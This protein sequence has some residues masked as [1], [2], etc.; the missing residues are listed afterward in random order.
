MPER[1]M[2]VGNAFTDMP[3]AFKLFAVAIL[4][5][6]C[7][8]AVH[9]GLVTH[10]LKPIEHKWIIVLIVGIEFGLLHWEP[11]KF[12]STGIAGSCLVYVYLKTK[13]LVLPAI[14]HFLTNLPAVFVSGE[15]ADFNETVAVADAGSVVSEI[16]LDSSAMTLSLGVSAGLFL[17]FCAAVP[18]L[19]YASSRLL[20]EKG[21]AD[22]CK[23]KKIIASTVSSI[24][25]AVAGLALMGVCF[26]KLSLYISSQ[27]I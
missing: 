12:L 2:A 26:V 23:K 21:T 9:R 25:I 3:F 10:F 24:V 14:M 18:W 16:A 17:A 19:M 20:A 4:P 7:E 13:N 27:I 8:E 1:F 6:I 5:P 22:P 15:T 11:V